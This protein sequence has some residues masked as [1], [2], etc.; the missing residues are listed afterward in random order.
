MTD[1]AAR[2]RE[3]E[4]DLEDYPDER[5]E[6]VTEL[7]AACCE[8][9]QHG[10]A[11][12]L[13]RDLIAQSEDW[14]A[15]VQLAGLCFDLG[16]TEDGHAELAALRAALRS[17][18]SAGAVAEGLAGQLLEANGDLDGALAWYDEA[19]SV[20]TAEEIAAAGGRLGWLTTAG[21]LIRGRRRVRARR[22]LPPDDL[23]R[24]MPSEQQI[25][26]TPF[27]TPARPA[28][29]Q[30]LR[31]L[32][33]PRAE[34]AAAAARWPSLTDP[35][36]ADPARYYPRLQRSWADATHDGVARIELV[37]ASVESIAAYADRA[38]TDIGNDA[39]RLAYLAERHDTGH[40]LHWPPPRNSACWCGSPA[41]YKKCCG[42]PGTRS[43]TS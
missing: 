37:P 3:L 5:T 6:I 28:V 25:L 13:L 23:D 10:R 29:P 15:R 7:A 21:P 14:T 34:L 19:I 16:R 27:P 20:L 36:L 33:W 1:A 17:G 30:I 38:G 26:T 31:V 39:T 18:G 22:G 24:S 11:E 8:A 12:G 35:D 9:G 2:I 4:R 42:R 32:Y 41:K 43:T 40:R